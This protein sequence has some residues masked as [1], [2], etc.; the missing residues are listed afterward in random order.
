VRE[1]DLRGRRVL[2]VGCGTGRVA[3]ALSERE[4]CRVWAVD[5]SAEMLEVARA[6]TGGR[7]HGRTQV[8]LAR[9]EAL[10][11]KPGWFE[12]VVMRLVV[13]LVD[14]PV[15]LAEARR[16]LGAGGR[17]A[18]ATFDPSHFDRYW[19]NRLFPSLEAIDRARF[20]TPE[21]LSGE[22][23]RAGFA[24]VRTTPLSQRAALDRETALGKIRGR[25]ISTFDLIGAEEYHAGLE[26]AERELPDTVDYA[27]EWVVVVARC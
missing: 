7:T 6:R 15:A 13:H 1:G 4:N 20:P 25:H 24:A 18:I 26:R 2:E 22:L 11:F 14:R 19:L 27:L 12:R 10:P 21:T 16:V 8:R 17:L 9:A 23:A 5:P 3:A